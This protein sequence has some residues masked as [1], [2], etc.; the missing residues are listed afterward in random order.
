MQPGQRI[1]SSKNE[2]Q[3]ADSSS[4]TIPTSDNEAKD[5]RLELVLKLQTQNVPLKELFSVYYLC[6]TS[7]EIDQ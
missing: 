7:L 3:P 4:L 2:N 1:K 6:S 5:A